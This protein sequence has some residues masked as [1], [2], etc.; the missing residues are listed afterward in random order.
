MLALTQR[1]TVLACGAGGKG[2]LG[3]EL[4]G[5]GVERVV[6]EAIESLKL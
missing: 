3:V 5:G 2:Q 4:A 6:P 1:G